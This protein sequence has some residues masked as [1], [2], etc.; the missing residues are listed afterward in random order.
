M[1]A[2]VDLPE[3]LGGGAQVDLG[4]ANV[5]VSQVGSEGR[6]A[7]VDVLAVDVDQQRV[8]EFAEV[9]PAVRQADA[10]SNTA[11]R[12][13]GV[14]Q[15]DAAVVAIGTVHITCLPARSAADAISK[16]SRLGVVMWTAATSLSASN[17]SSVA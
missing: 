13:L 16:C 14:D 11:L 5:H 17:S 9:L 10:T 3:Q 6:Q 4:R 15:F 8:N 2:L 12:Q 7:G 1:E